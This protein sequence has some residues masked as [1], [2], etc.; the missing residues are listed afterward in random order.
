MNI[1]NISKH[2]LTAA[3]MT[4]AS[5]AMAQGLNSAYYTE[6]YKFRHDLNP[7][8]ANDQSYISIPALG[9]ISVN[10]HGNFGYQDVVMKNPRYGLDA[11]AKKMTTFM[12]PYIS[13][14]DALEG[15][16]SGN[17]RITGDVNIALLSAG[18]RAFGGY[19]TIEVNSKTSFGV[20]LP[21]ELFEFAK[22]TGNQTYNIGDIRAHGMSY[23]ELAFGHSHQINKKLRIGAKLKF[24]FGIAR[25]DVEMNDVKADL[26][27]NDKWLISAQANAHMSMKGFTYKQ[28]SKEYNDPSKGSYDYVNDVDVD[29]AGL[30]GFGMAVD[31]GGVYKIND[32]W[33]VNAA[34]LDLGFMR[35]N[36]DMLAVNRENTFTFDG[37]HDMYVKQNHGGE[38]F[39]DQADKY[40]DQLADFANLSDQGDQGGRTTG[41]GATL[42]L[43][44]SYTLPSYK[45]MT[46]GFLSSTRIKGAYSWTEGRLSANWTPLK[47]L[48]GGVNFAVNSFTASM[49]WVLNIHPKGYNLFIGM[50]HLLGKMSKEYIPLSSNASLAIG[51]NIT[52]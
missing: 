16:S 47:W 32:S 20:A 2:L 48:D 40:G 14:S 51:M 6:D 18:F 25:A 12:N 28:K 22:N 35:W 27:A 34:I 43:G 38:T 39:D 30:S 41:L 1:H 44:A 37:F 29:G 52:W 36:N 7:A 4:V 24:L 10:T 3:L 33:T 42:N 19:N 13:T 45:K 49:G 17:N 50:D 46:F 5:S 21:Y 8:Y 11:N 26:A 31:L 15:F 23:A 9:N